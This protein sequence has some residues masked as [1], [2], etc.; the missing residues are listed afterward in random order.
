MTVFKAALGICGFNNAEAAE[1]FGT[2]ESTVKHWSAGRRPVP[3]GIWAMLATLYD[4]I[5]EVSEHGLD[6]VER[7][8]PEALR[9]LAIHV[10]GSM[11]PQP[12][13]DAAAAMFVLTRLL[14]DEPAD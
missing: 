13:L 7:D 5:V 8:N 14:D 10:H 11:L 6:T 12:A 9:D 3:D 1:F 4:Q 2:S